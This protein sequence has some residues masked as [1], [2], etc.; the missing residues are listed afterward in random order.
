M[1]TSDVNSIDRVQITNRKARQLWALCYQKTDQI[2]NKRNEWD[3]PYNPDQIPSSARSKNQYSRNKLPYNNRHRNKPEKEVSIFFL[4]QTTIL[5]ITMN[6]CQMPR[7]PITLFYCTPQYRHVMF[8]YFHVDTG[9]WSVLAGGYPLPLEYNSFWICEYAF[10]RS[11]IDKLRCC[12]NYKNSPAAI[13][14]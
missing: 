13:V 12:W 14:K 10:P 3:C 1:T 8:P 4:K 2:K 6:E 5:C 9:P 7:A 11:V